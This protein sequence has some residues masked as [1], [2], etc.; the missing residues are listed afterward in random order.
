MA[1]Q[2]QVTEVN[3]AGQ[4][5]DWSP[6]RDSAV[7]PDC[8]SHELD[9]RQ[10]FRVRRPGDWSLAGYPAEVPGGGRLGVPVHCV[11]EDRA[12]G[13]EVA[14][15]AGVTATGRPCLRWFDSSPGS[16]AAA[17]GLRLRLR[18]ADDP[19]RHRGAAPCARGGIR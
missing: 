16:H 13:A 10:V 4:L 1:T 15:L 18:T 9:V 6:Y 5:V 8:G 7:C 14:L 17:H 2:E 19:G 11:R 12:G 3:A